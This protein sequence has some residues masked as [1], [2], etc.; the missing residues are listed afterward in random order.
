MEE[1]GMEWN[2]K[3]GSTRNYVDGTINAASKVWVR[4][5]LGL[6]LYTQWLLFCSVY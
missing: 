4:I 1:N 2:S 3:T 6:E 5:R